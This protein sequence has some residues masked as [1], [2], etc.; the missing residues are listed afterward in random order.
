[1]HVCVSIPNLAPVAVILNTVNR[2]GNHLHISLCKLAAELS[3][4]G[5]LGGADRSEDPWVG[6]QDA[7]STEK[8]THER[9]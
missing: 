6:K 3:G 1:M 4:A 9:Q 2:Q 8:K 7:P 5:E